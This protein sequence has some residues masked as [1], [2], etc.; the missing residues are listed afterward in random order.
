MMEYAKE[1][2]GIDGVAMTAHIVA[3]G[4]VV[5]GELEQEKPCDFLE[6]LETART[7]LVY[8]LNLF[9][10]MRKASADD[11]C[12]NAGIMC[13]CRALAASLEAARQQMKWAEEQDREA[14]LELSIGLKEYTDRAASCR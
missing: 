2:M 1:L 8:A 5:G 3:H 11:R 13:A 10:E 12:R 14:V 9:D 4:M 7:A 6:R